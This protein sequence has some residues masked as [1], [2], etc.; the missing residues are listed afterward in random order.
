M[1]DSQSSSLFLKPSLIIIGNG[2]ATGRL[3]DEIIKRDANKYQITVIGNEPYGS[4][5]RIMLSSVLA[6]DT[7]IAVLFKK[8]TNGIKIIILN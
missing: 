1:G 2:M 3:L 4:Y 5:N 7:T 6:G 8:I